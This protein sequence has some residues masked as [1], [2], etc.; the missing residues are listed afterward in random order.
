MDHYER[1]SNITND[2]SC[3]IFDVY[4]EIENNRAM[5]NDLIY[6]KDNKVINIKQRNV[7]NLIGVLYCNSTTTYGHNKKKHF[8]YKFCPKNS[9]YPNFYVAFN[10]NKLKNKWI[11]I[12]FVSWESTSKLPIGKCEHVIGDVDDEY[13]EYDALIYHFRAENTNFFNKLKLKVNIKEY[14]NKFIQGL[15]DPERIDF[16]KDYV[17]SIDPEDCDDID[18][19][20]HV[21]RENDLYKVH[22]HI[23]DVSH[24]IEENSPL[25]LEL[26]NR[27]YTIYAPHKKINMLPDA[28]VKIISLLPKEL[29][30]T[31]TVI[32]TMD[33][34]GIIQ[35]CQ[36]VKGIIKCR[37]FTYDN[38]LEKKSNNNIL[39]LYQMLNPQDPLNM[40]KMV[41]FY[42]IM[43]NH[44]VAKYLVNKHSQMLLRTH[45]VGQ[46]TNLSIKNTLLQ[47]YLN[48]LQSNS[49]E[50][51]I[52][53]QTANNTNHEGL[54]LDTY[55]HF[56]SPIRRYADVI[57]HRLLF[58]KSNLN[59]IVVNRMNGHQRI[60]KRL[61][62]KMNKI[63]LTYKLKHETK[64]T[65][66]YIIE[67]L[68]KKL[69][70]YLPEYRMQIN[71]KPINKKFE[72]LYELISTDDQ[73]E[74]VDNKIYKLYDELQIQIGGYNTNGFGK[75][76]LEIIY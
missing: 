56:T 70:L 46:Q 58:N 57:I 26:Q 43:A 39:K 10:G 28:L 18:D 54:N 51:K 11:Q 67:I 27:L 7:P 36:M 64:N 59:Q 76:K 72:H 16:R 2:T 68:E 24:Y 69:V 1:Y 60:L 5:H 62:R 3:T 65:Q 74:I 75:L 49:A 45:K 38:F 42:M 20:I 61:E 44:Q 29:R 25:D 52:V 48:I 63:E 22:I 40:H 32:I 12:S 17:V 30:L 71:Y 9:K 35:D 4:G 19:A 73:L 50:Y 6:Y 23:A 34:K 8:Y 15:Q 37:Q 55:T 66:A 21:T 33:D 47:D 14:E 31:T 53:D 41:E 13:V